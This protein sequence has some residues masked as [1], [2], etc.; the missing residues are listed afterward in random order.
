MNLAVI[1][2]LIW[3]GG[4][5]GGNAVSLAY[6]LSWAAV[7]GA[8]LQFSVQAPTVYTYL[9][10]LM[11]HIDIRSLHVA[12]VVAAFIPVFISRG[13]LQISGFIDLQLASFLPKGNVLL[14]YAQT[15]YMLP[16][17]LFGMSVSAAEL[18]AMSSAVG[19]ESE[20][21]A[22]LR[23]RLSAGLEKISFFVIPSAVLFL[24]LGNVAAALLYRTGRFNQQDVYFVWAALAG[25]GIGLLTQT[26][27]RLYS[28][29]FYA[30][31]D[32]R[33]PMRYAL[34]RISLTVSLGYLFSLPLPRALGIDPNW[35]VAGL[36]SSAGLA[37]WVEYF[38]LRRGL[39]A[40]IGHVAF[41]V[42][43]VGKL[44]AAALA[45]AAI[46]LLIEWRLHLGSPVLR[47]LL[48][49]IPF[50]AFYLVITHLLGL[51]GFLSSMLERFGLTRS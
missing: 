11:G 45:A 18:P 36:S 31:R 30:L 23:S 46:A 40:R 33:T 19:S 35:G 42:S 8:I 26:M 13:I 20:I 50:G 38:L 29:T 7:A 27:G 5:R 2:A 9:R 25:C 48:I 47:G 28:S 21:F 14:T 24:A 12:A 32:T 41:S 3:Q 51:S 22:T 39:Q 4:F 17:S 1:A 10:P 15:L 44:W 49:L 16:V 6:A 43:R 37:A 34:I